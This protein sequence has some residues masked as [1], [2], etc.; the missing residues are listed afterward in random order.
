M[1]DNA[2]SIPRD[3]TTAQSR[4]DT[5]SIFD[6]GDGDHNTGGGGSVGVMTI[7]TTITGDQAA[8]A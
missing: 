5:A 2:L 6:W 4:S 3:K 1:H 7:T 8:Q